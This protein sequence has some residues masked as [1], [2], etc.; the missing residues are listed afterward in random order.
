LRLGSGVA[1]G[2]VL[3][4]CGGSSGKKATTGSLRDIIASRSQRLTVVAVQGEI[5]KGESVRYPFALFDLKTNQRYTGGTAR[6]WAAQNQTDK[7]AGPFA[8]TWHDEMLGDRGV[9]TTRLP[10]RT[11][12][13]WLVLVEATPSEAA[14]QKLIGGTQVGVGRRTEQPAPGDKAIAVASPT[15]SNHRGV[16]P[17]CTAK[18]QCS[19]HDVSLDAALRSGKPTVLVIGTPAFCESRTCGPIVEILDS[20][21]S[22]T[23]KGAV[24]FVHVELYKDNTE[25]PA[26]GILAPAAQA[27][28]ISEEPALYFIKP[29]GT[30]AERFVGASGLDE[31]QEQT[32]ALQA[33]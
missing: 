3:T 29:D 24:N 2:A 11:D 18:P 30:I 7:A 5:L 23:A 28:K 20:V 13:A 17:I 10:L 31:V 12:G 26:K 27:W 33:R 8:A 16:N 6:L 19:M 32:L 9:Y 1:M 21:K 15:P 4:A 25:A 14:D 22:R